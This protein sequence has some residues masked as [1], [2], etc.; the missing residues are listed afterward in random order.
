[1]LY[2]GEV[3]CKHNEGKGSSPKTELTQMSE[4]ASLVMLINSS[5]E[6]LQFATK[7]SGGMAAS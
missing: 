5:N 2:R 1:L 6:M 7:S 4:F 3:D